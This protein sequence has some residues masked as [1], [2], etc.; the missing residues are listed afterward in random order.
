M[1]ESTLMTCDEIERKLREYQSRKIQ[2][3]M[4]DLEKFRERYARLVRDEILLY[5]PYR[6]TDAE[7]V[8]KAFTTDIRPRALTQMAVIE[9]T[10]VRTVEWKIPYDIIEWRVGNT[11]STGWDNVSNFLRRRTAVDTLRPV[12]VTISGKPIAH[13][14]NLEALIGKKVFLS[15][16]FT[17]KKLRSCGFGR[18]FQM[19]RLYGNT[20]KMA[21]TIRRAMCRAKMEMLKR[22]VENPECFIYLGCP[23]G[24]MDIEGPINRFLQKV[25]RYIHGDIPAGLPPTFE[26]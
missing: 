8:E 10:G 12:R 15:H 5:N 19:V 18:S 14:E 6:F 26:L 17:V 1:I 2:N 21:D 7:V 11:G 25:N 20:A 13:A 22:M 23:K 24:L 16:Y 9:F 4:P 3:A